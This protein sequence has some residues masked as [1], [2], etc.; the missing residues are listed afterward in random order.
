MNKLFRGTGVA[1]VTPFKD[2]AIDYNGLERLINFNIEGGVEFL[3][4]LGTTGESVTLT[5]EEKHAVLD[6]TVKITA[7]RIPIVAGFGGNN[8][9]AVIKSIQNYH[10]KGIAGIL[11]ASP[12][13]NKPTQ[14]G[15]YQHF[16]A[17]EAV[18][19]CPII[20]YNVPG[21]TA[22]NMTAATTLRLA[23]ASNKFVAVKEASGNLAQCMQIIK[24]KKPAHFAVLSG[25]DNL[26]LPLLA[27]GAD[28]LISVVGNAYPQIYSDLV[29]AG[30][31][32]DFGTA[33]NLHYQLMDLVDLL[34]VDGN[35]AGVKHALNCLG[36]C[37]EELRLPLVPATVA[38]QQ[39]I[40]KIVTQLK[41]TSAV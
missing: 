1:L 10:F 39:A 5:E 2:G 9:A 22:S 29:R 13:Y 17:I 23:N 20:L 30:L 27:C 26:T 15:I 16:M 38:T 8:T 12:A 11:S 41:E 7:G 3:V 18:A 21:R 19:P 14:E 25:D 33:R 31:V 28:G 36:I 35:P 40:G 34:F 6:F 32:G 37:G 24:G 4:S